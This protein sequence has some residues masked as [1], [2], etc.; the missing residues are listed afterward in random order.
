MF[1]LLVFRVCFFLAD[2]GWGGGLEGTERRKKER[3]KAEVWSYDTIIHQVRTRDV[4]FS[5][6]NKPWRLSC[7]PLSNR[8]CELVF[9]SFCVGSRRV[10]FLSFFRQFVPL[11]RRT[12]LRPRATDALVI[13]PPL[14]GFLALWSSHC[15]ANNRPDRDD[16]ADPYYKICCF[17]WHVGPP[18]MLPGLH[19]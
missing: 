18:G 15:R 10:F 13:C 2:L 9:L 6:Q 14:S 12:H 1:L 16:S 5:N 4:W 7:T 19:P 11:S 3:K 8:K 17:L